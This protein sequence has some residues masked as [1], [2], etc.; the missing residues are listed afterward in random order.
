MQNNKT[1]HNFPLCSVDW[2]VNEAWNFGD[3]EMEGS[4]LD[5][6]VVS[7]VTTLNHKNGRIISIDPSTVDESNE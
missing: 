4:E 1:T 7:V 6:N 3:P 5:D 2:W